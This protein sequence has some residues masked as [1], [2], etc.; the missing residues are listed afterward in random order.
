M[1]VATCKQYLDIGK[2]FSLVSLIPRSDDFIISLMSLTKH[3]KTQISRRFFEEEKNTR[4][5]F[6]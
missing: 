5:E 3:R 2:D 1:K 6:F 4:K